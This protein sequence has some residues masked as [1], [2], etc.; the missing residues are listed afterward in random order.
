MF[1]LHHVV[2][3][4]LVRTLRIA[5]AETNATM[6]PRTMAAMRGRAADAIEALA[7]A[8]GCEA[9]R[10]EGR[11]EELG[12]GPRRLSELGARRDGIDAAVEAVLAR[13]QLAFTPQPPDADEVRALIESAW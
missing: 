9:G 4:T 8:L 3:Q 5:H 12:G 2:C 11:I 6:L 1:A 13:P 7:L 10:I